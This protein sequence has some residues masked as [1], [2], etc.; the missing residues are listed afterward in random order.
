MTMPLSTNPQDSKKSKTEAEL[1]LSLAE[2]TD[3][4]DVTETLLATM[5]CEEALTTC[6]TLSNA[7]KRK[8]DWKGLEVLKF[9][10]D[11]IDKVRKGNQ[12]NVSRF[13]ESLCHKRMSLR[14]VID[15]PMS[16]LDL[17]DEYKNDEAFI[18]AIFSKHVRKMVK[19]SDPKGQ[20]WN[21]F[22]NLSKSAERGEWKGHVLSKYSH[23]CFDTPIGGAT[24][25]FY[26]P[27][28]DIWKWMAWYGE[29]LEKAYSEEHMRLLKE[30][31]QDPIKWESLNIAQKNNSD[32]LDAVREREKERG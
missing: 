23:F 11:E 21:I 29:E 5:D 30:V 10:E 14:K 2:L 25:A 3:N 6:L 27:L 4:R 1:P 19:Q 9:S 13:F 31:K 17:K 24:K 7:V 12:E 32:F 18:R 16:F 15:N 28:P 8:C 22:Y 26:L 20:G